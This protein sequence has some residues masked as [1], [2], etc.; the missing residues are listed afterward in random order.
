MS[1]VIGNVLPDSYA[2][3]AGIKKGDKLVAVN[4]NPINDVLDYQ[5]YATDANVVC[6]IENTNGQ[7]REV[8]LDNDEYEDLGME[9]S[10]YLMD[11]KHSCKNKC[12]FCFIDQLPNGMRESLYFKDDDDRLSFLFGNYITLTNLTQ[13]EI[14]RILKIKISPINISIHTTNPELRVKMMANP[15]AGKALDFIKQL[16]DGG[17]SLNCQLVLCP[18]IN[19]GD[20]LIR[21]LTDLEALFPALQ[22]IAC[23]PVGL[24]DHRETL[25]PLEEY[26]QTT[27]VKTIDIIESFSK[28]WNIKYGSRIAYPADEFFLLA[29]LEIPQASYYASFDQLEDGVGLIAYTKETFEEG[30]TQF[31]PDDRAVNI[32]IATGMAAYPFICGL[33]DVLKEKWH[34]LKCNVFPIQNDCFGH[35]IVVAGLVT[36]N[37]IINQLRGNNLGDKLLLPECMLNDSKERFLDDVTPKNLSKALKI[38]VEFVNNDGYSIIQAILE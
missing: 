17:I 30:L 12:I 25:F 2:A 26:D 18:G 31:N 15:N 11:T 27:A 22:S 6:I 14:D 28:K 9:F 35:S 38:P 3:D 23:V 24:S 36:G 21:S 16:A 20:E 13:R 10:T 34:N 8:T 5:F 19:D 7:Q 29:N 4:D 1:V 32:S 33:V 37:D